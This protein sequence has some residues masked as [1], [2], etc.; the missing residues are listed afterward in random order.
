[1]L[2]ADEAAVAAAVAEYE[3][4][5]Q[6]EAETEAVV[7]QEGG[8]AAAQDGGD[9]TADGWQWRQTEHG[10]WERVQN[11]PAPDFYQEDD[12]DAAQPGARNSTAP[13]MEEEDA[14]VQQ[15]LRR[16][17]AER[18]EVLTRQ[19]SRREAA[20]AAQD[21]AHADAA[22]AAA[23]AAAAEEAAL[24]R[25]KMATAARAEALARRRVLTAA[26]ADRSAHADIIRRRVAVEERRQ[27]E[28]GLQTLA[29]GLSALSA[30]AGAAALRDMP[31][32]QRGSIL[33]RMAPAPAAAALRAMSSQHK[34]EALADAQGAARGADAALPSR[35]AARSYGSSSDADGE[36]DIMTTIV[37]GQGRAAFATLLEHLTVLDSALSTVFEPMSPGSIAAAAHL[38][39]TAV[40]QSPGAVETS[41]GAAFGSPTETPEENMAR[42][43]APAAIV[44]MDNRNAEQEATTPSGWMEVRPGEWERVGD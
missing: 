17:A 24:A 15:A 9:P 40:L 39:A 33:L 26:A 10:V 37:D 16:A 4:A 12:T 41:A 14:G 43:A 27:R 22:A 13:G 3:R 2:Q 21:A 28:I 25:D 11:T 36:V 35:T 6:E 34:A 29:M 38:T 19:Q 18:Q 1:L 32:S 31:G 8:D 30:G 44:W 7:A 5:M 20:Q 23:A 42:D